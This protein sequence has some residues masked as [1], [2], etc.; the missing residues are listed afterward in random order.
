MSRAIALLSIAVF[1]GACQR[2]APP[3]R[4]LVGSW[5]EVYHAMDSI[6]FLTFEPDHTFTVSIDGFDSRM[7]LDSWGSWRI[8]G[9]ELVR[10]VTYPEYPATDEFRDLAA[11]QAQRPRHIRSEIL[12]LSQTTLKI[13]APLENPSHDLARFEYARSKRPRKPDI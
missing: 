4:M 1:A 13:M 9:Q 5:S 11:F 10:D 7:H 6:T 2:S 12:E 3:E 8:E